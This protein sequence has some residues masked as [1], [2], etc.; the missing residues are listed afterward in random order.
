MEVVVSEISS[1]LKA[2]EG[3]SELGDFVVQI[4]GAVA[5]ERNFGYAVS[6]L[7]KLSLKLGLEVSCDLLSSILA[8]FIH[9]SRVRSAIIQCS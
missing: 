3:K 9:A 6:K 7:L 4:L 1:N 8:N 5:N 2:F